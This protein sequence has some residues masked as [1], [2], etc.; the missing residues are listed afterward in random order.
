MRLKQNRT[1]TQGAL[2]FALITACA[3]LTLAACAS[4]LTL[5]I[6]VLAAAALDAAAHSSTPVQIPADQAAG[7]IL[8]KVTPKYPVD[9]KKAGIQGT[10]TLTATISKHGLIEHLSVVSG[11]S[12]LQ[13]SAL[14]AVR[15]WVYKPFLLNGKPVPVETTIHVI[16]SLAK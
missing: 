15:P 13:R 4:A 12:T 11:P 2:R 16:Y 14:D 3:L 9:A 1:T 8:K 5:H 6:N 7:H 10:V